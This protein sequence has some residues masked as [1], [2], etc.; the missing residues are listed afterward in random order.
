MDACLEATNDKS[1]WTCSITA[2][3]NIPRKMYVELWLKATGISTASLCMEQMSL[4]EVMDFHSFMKG[5]S[6]TQVVN[7]I[8]EACFIMWF[9]TC[10]PW[11]TRVTS[12]IP[13]N[14]L[15]FCHR[16]NV[17]QATQ[18]ASYI[19]L[20]MPQIFNLLSFV[21]NHNSINVHEFWPNCRISMP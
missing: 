19:H 8:R 7:N 12:I 5:K 16:S 4:H 2:Q 15:R 18:S 9:H 6:T 11:S 17:E 20:T 10:G 14:L 21:R 1:L 3:L 13:C